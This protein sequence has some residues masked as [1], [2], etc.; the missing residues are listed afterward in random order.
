MSYCRFSSDGFQCDL[1]CYEGAD[2]Y[3]T[4]VASKRAKEKGPALSDYVRF[5][6]PTKKD[7]QDPGSAAPL[8]DEK[9][10]KDYSEAVTV[11][12]TRQEE[13]TEDER[14]LYL[15]FEGAG[16]TFVTSTL[17][18]F[19]EVVV[20]MITRGASVPEGVVEMIQGEIELLGKDHSP[21]KDTDEPDED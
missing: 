7:K 9:T 10:I 12:Q 6:P 15:D 16:E 20:E 19:K 8:W 17:E 13:L 2:G 18:E 11:W 1:Y 14:Y 5:L 3:Y 4:H 21:V